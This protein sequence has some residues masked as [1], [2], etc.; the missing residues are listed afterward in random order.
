MLQF[1]SLAPWRV[2][3]VFRFSLVALTALV[4]ASCSDLIH[5]EAADVRAHSPG[6]NKWAA[7]TTPKSSVIAPAP[8][9]AAQASAIPATSEGKVKAL[10]TKIAA[11]LAAHCS[12]AD[13]ADQAAFERCKQALFGKSEIRKVLADFTIWG[14]QNSDPAKTLKETNLTQFA[15]DV[16]TGLYLPLFM[17]D[18]SHKVEYS[19]SEKLYR[20]EFGALFRNRLQPG[21]FPYPFWHSEEKWRTYEKANGLLLWFDPAKPRVSVAQFTPRGELRQPTV[22]SHVDHNFDGKWMWTDSQGE[23]QPKVTV[24]DGLFRSDNP[25]L[26][27]LDTSY[28]QFALSLREGQ[29]MGCH[30]PDNPDKMK[31]L[32]LLQT[33]AHAAAEIRRVMT[34]VR[35]N[36]MPLDEFTGIEEPLSNE[37]KE[38]LLHRATSFE[39][40]VEAAKAWERSHGSGEQRSSTLTTTS[41]RVGQPR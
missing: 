26:G 40:V 6:P 19:Q 12:V 8:K 16:L 1:S 38:L 27:T 31:R 20:V 24:F 11:E 14:R 30:V 15:P 36:R 9:I 37:K 3:R 39:A 17:Y 2:A 35:T 13:P 22:A 32:V 5:E 7:R 4:S 33:P 23:A 28:K 41:G 21:Q 34:A 29:C 10:A 25:F 18:G